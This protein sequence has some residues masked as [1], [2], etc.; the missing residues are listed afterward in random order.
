MANQEQ[1]EIL[2]K[3]TKAWNQWRDDHIDIRI[4]LSQA[5]LTEIKLDFDVYL[6]DANLREAVLKGSDLS[7]A[8][9]QRAELQQA[10][11]VGAN[12]SRAYLRRADLQQAKL[13]GA[14][15]SYAYLQGADL[16][17]A[18]LRDVNFRE[19]SLM[20]ADINRA[21]L[22]G[23]DLSSSSLQGANLTLAQIKGAKF[24]RASI[25]HTIF[26]F[27][28]LLEATGLEFVE[29]IGPSI[30]GAE[31]I[32][33]SKGKI[34][35][36]FLRGCGLSDADI[37]YARLSNPDL[38]NEE[39]NKILY[40]IYDLRASRAIQISPLF[41]SYNHRDSVFVDK[42]ESCLNKKGVRFWRDIHNMKS[43]RMEK[44]VDRAMR[45]NP[46]VL[47]ILSEHSLQSDWVEHEV[48]TARSLEKEMKRDVLCPITLDDTWKNSPWA[49]RIMEQVMEYNI[50][51]FSAWKDDSKFENVFNKLIDGL[52][53]F[54]K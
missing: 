12:L 28:N 35:E 25:G 11:L 37:E 9:L 38:S 16:S 48:R 32:R 29:H 18:D 20:N 22:N 1:L 26:N 44:Q 13:N 24:S 21:N 46:T 49:K 34:P 19:A 45:L 50:L 47:L 43:G 42:I 51:D 6:N 10:D 31:T 52:D 14:D 17:Y 36:V 7:G 8:D 3:G 5:D 15:F 30:L 39:I 41:I 27:I 33:M 4:D 54:Y 53:L 40:K 23:A 2:K